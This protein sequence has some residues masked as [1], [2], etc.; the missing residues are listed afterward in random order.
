MKIFP[1]VAGIDRSVSFYHQHMWCC[2]QKQ[3]NYADDT[4]VCISITPSNAKEIFSTLQ[5]CVADI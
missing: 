5:K 1:L 4:P 2:V 3:K